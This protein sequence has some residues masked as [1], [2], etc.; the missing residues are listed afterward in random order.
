[1]RTIYF[2]TILLFASVSSFSQITLKVKVISKSHQEVL[3]SASVE[4][5]S[6]KNKYLQ[7]TDSKGVAEFNNLPKSEELIISVQ[8]V[9][10]QIFNSTIHLISNKEILVE[11]EDEFFF[12]EPLEI[13]SIRSSSKS[14]F[15][16]TN[17]S[18]A[19][20]EKINLGADLPFLLNN[21]PSV[22]V[23]SDAGNGI[24]YT[25]MT[26]RGTDMTRINMTVNGIPY[27]DPE[28][29]GIFLVDLPDL[30]SSINSIQIQRGIGTSSNGAGAFGATINISTNEFNEKAY[31]EINN[32]VGSFN[33]LKNTIKIGSGLLNNA[34]TIDARLSNIKSDG[35]IDRASTNLQSAYLSAVYSNKKTQLRFNI[36]TGK[37]KTYQ[38]WNGI[39]ENVLKTNRTFNSSGTEKTG[40][41]YENETDNYQQDH[42]QFFWNQI[43]NLNWNFNTALY[44]TNGKG[45]YEQYKA[46]QKFSKYGLPNYIVGT[47]TIFKTDLIR[48]LWLDNQ[49]MGQIFSAEYK[50]NKTSLTLGG[51]WNIF[52]GDHFGKIIWA[53]VGIPKDYKWYNTPAK[54]TDASFYSKWIYQIN[55]NWNTFIDIQYRVVNYT[56]DGFRYNPTLNVNRKFNFLNPKMGIYYSK[57]NL[58]AYLSYA[59]SKKEPNR[60]DFEANAIQQPLHE[61]LHDIESG[62]SYTKKNFQINS[63]LYYMSYVNQL[64][65]TGKI[66]DVGAYTRINVPKS[67][68]LGFEIQSSYNFSK[69]LNLSGNI[70]LSRNKIKEFTENIDNY[71]SG[72]QQSILYN[73]KDIAFSPNII[74][75]LTL[76]YKP[77]KNADLS[78]F[79]KYVGRQYLDNTQ[80][81]NRSLNNFFTQD[82]RL[83][84]SLNIKKIKSIDLLLQVNNI[85]N[86]KYEANG[87]TFSY[88][89][90]GAQT[91]E[92]YYFPM[93]G[94]NYFMGLNIKL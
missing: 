3:E 6:I 64:I 89:A 22:V 72:I 15:T 12:L 9:S 14:P 46:A 88:I 32:S 77:F 11:L 62:L 85:Y 60:N 49:L 17:I 51:A 43:I 18:K 4:L 39:S 54:K 53:N 79:N 63:T 10:K 91:T 81:L 65:L 13:K 19:D 24:G 38:A 50:K 73:N 31:A 61:Q 33:S 2:I 16:K 83:N 90:S 25:G 1:M 30:S 48:Q 29:Q 74:S 80:N 8:H 86:K 57:N 82:L 40:T 23:N 68:R 36:I 44:I 76:N 34:F 93:A 20:L 21:T 26:I 87:Y 69:K 66:N 52:T 42:F 59:H 28:S 27:N 41:P 56:M 45:Y 58:Q 75:S 37:E 78:I 71:D 47:T 7:I 84:Y 55:Q 5:K 35:F 94:T 70:T 92:N 67:Y